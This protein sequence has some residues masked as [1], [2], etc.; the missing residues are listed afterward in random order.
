MAGDRATALLEGSRFFDVRWVESTGSTNA[1]LLALA[2]AGGPDGVVL[3]TDHQSAGR[4]RLGRTWEAPP[5]S[6]LLVSVLVRPEL[7]P[8]HLHLLTTAAAVA[9]SDA[10]DAVAGVRPRLKWPNDL[11]VAAPDGVDRKL[12]GIL[13][14]ASASGGDVVAVV[15]GMGLNVAWPTP[16][17]PELA[18]TAT[19]LNLETDTPVDREDLLVAWLLGLE[20][21]LA[22]LDSPAGRD[23]LLLRYRHLSA[24]LGREVRVELASGAVRGTAVDVSPGGHLLVDIAGDLVEVTAG[25]VV[26]LRPLD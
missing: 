26:H 2:A 16:L 15:I 18:A 5:G 10:C 9:A 23:A 17:P 8:D 24:T 7:G 21:L 19:A 1:D 25:D 22:P 12:A 14:E 4:G 20:A 13:A 11:V 6:S 3:V